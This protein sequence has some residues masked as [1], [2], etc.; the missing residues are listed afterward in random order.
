MKRMFVFLVLCERVYG[1]NMKQEMPGYGCCT[2]RDFRMVRI[3]GVAIYN[4]P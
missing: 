4:P 2:I 1:G 3:C